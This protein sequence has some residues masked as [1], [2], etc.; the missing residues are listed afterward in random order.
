MENKIEPIIRTEIIL[1]KGWLLIMDYDFL[2]T[3]SKGDVV[4][5]EDI[6]YRVYCCVWDIEK[7][8]MQILIE[9]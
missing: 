2:F 4:L 6:K 5:W 1:G 8:K 9:L 3:M 7:N